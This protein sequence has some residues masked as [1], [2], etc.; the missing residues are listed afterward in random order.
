MNRRV[1][2]T[3]NQPENT[4]T[5]G[6]FSDLLI[7]QGDGV[8]LVFDEITGASTGVINIRAYMWADISVRHAELFCPITAG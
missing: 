7:G 4:L 5:L 8:D 2:E 1:Y 6:R 3:T